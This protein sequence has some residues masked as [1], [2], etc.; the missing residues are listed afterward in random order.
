MFRIVVFFLGW[1]FLQTA[2]AQSINPLPA[3]DRDTIPGAPV[4]FTAEDASDYIRQLLE[5]DNIWRPV[6]GDSLKRA[7]TRLVD[8]LSEPYD[9]VAIRLKDIDFGM[10][11]PQRSLLFHHD[12]LP[13]KW[14]NDTLFFVDTLRL[15][16]NPLITHKTVI[17]KA[18]DTTIISLAERLPDMKPALDS[19]IS[20]RDTITEHVVDMRYLE[21]RN[22]RLHYLSGDSV[23]PPL[24]RTN[25]RK[26]VK[27]LSD[28]LHV[29]VTETTRVYLAA[30]E[31][32]FGILPGPQMPDSLRYAVETMLLHAFQRD[33]IPLYFTDVDGATTPFWLTAQAKELHRY[34]VKNN[35]RDSITV[36]IGN[37]SK[38]QVSFI[39]EDDVQLERLEKKRVDDVPIVSIT[40]PRMLASM[41]PIREIPV[42]WKLGMANSFILN[43]TH[44]SNWSK[45]GENSFSSMLDTRGTAL[46]TNSETKIKWETIGRLRYGTTN[47]REHGFR[48]N[49]DLV[50]VNS[51]YNKV[52]RN[53]IDFSAVFYMKTQV[54]KGF[55]YPNDSVVV[56]KFLNPG[57]F[58]VGMGLEYKPFKNT[59][60]NF[61]ALSYKNTFVLDTANIN[62]TRHGVA[63]DKRSRQEMGGQ[64]VIRNTVSILDGL[65]MSNNI[66]LF[67]GY[68][69]KPQNVDVDWEINLDK[70]INW[71]FMVRLNFHFIYDDDVRFPLFDN[72]NEPVLLPD[73]SQKRVPKLQFKQFL[74]L[75]LSFKI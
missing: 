10:V 6:V 25:G 72:N 21:S 40:P 47:T 75:T 14:L 30:K 16:R 51:Q 39:L 38:Y 60:I 17:V 70:Q 23:I 26:S 62:Q 4:V 41:E 55:N 59:T 11:N 18:P 67:S 2:H 54:A 46:Y 65:N 56:S 7:L 24:I 9:S 31:S 20:L 44:L 33:S 5:S 45:G 49:T 29:V 53:K 42:Y 50:E 37:P 19:L 1:V 22:V 27:F 12:T 71:Y 74:G 69:D 48:T 15:D 64:L 73:G 8:H 58:T 68:L 36:W 57:T 13:L 28:S 52:M 34:W 61:S 63:A 32:P 35:A 3:A 43:Q 66:R